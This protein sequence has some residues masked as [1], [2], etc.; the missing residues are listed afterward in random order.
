MEEAKHLVRTKTA[1]TEQRLKQLYET[2]VSGADYKPLVASVK[3]DLEELKEALSV[4]QGTAKSRL[5]RSLTEQYEETYSSLKSEL[6]ALV[7]QLEESSWKKQLL[8]SGQGTVDDSFASLVL[9]EERG[10]DSS[11]SMTSAILQLAS[12]VRSSLSNQ[13]R[14]LEGVGNKVVRFAELCL[15]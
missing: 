4:M 2:Q 11:L 7:R 13:K 12:D 10:L 9:R 8:G 6:E 5:A 14:R 1:L 3:L 15:G